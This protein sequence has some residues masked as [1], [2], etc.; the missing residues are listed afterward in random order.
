MP[1]EQTRASIEPSAPQ[2]EHK[3]LVGA[4]TPHLLSG[5]ADTR[6][7]MLDVII[8]LLPAA[9]LAPV[10]FGANAIVVIA[11]AVLAAEATEYV[12]KL[13]MGRDTAID[14]SAAVTGLLLAMLLPAT[15]PWYWVAVGAA[16][17]IGVGKMAYGGLGQNP[18]NPALVAYIFLKASFPGRF[19]TMP[20]NRLADSVDSVTQATPLALNQGIR[21][22]TSTLADVVGVSKAQMFWGLK[23][24][25]LGEVSV[26]ALLVGAAYLLARRIISWHA[27]VGYIGTV[28]V[29]GSA[30]W[31][32][33]PR[34][35]PDPLFHML[36]G[37]LV[38]GAFFMATDP[39]STP[40]TRKGQLVFGVGCGVMTIVIRSFGGFPEGVAFSILLM[41]ALAP[42]IDN[43]V[44]APAQRKVK[45]RG[46]KDAA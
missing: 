35:A 37:G 11:V 14:L 29:L 44:V 23:S 28:F 6:A 16:I 22:G 7:I 26:A 15:M 21:L 8:A 1:G 2:L 4:P 24:G 27:P 18:F 9:I 5:G 43:L 41:N 32:A 42:A 3:V 17:A 25:A 38:L 36:A 31:L 40:I 13:V 46:S 39:S 10:F 45:T 30:V 34:S 33:M 20:A 19:A 12:A